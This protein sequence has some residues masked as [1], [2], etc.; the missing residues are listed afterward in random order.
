M[1]GKLSRQTLGNEA[2][3]QNSE[4]RAEQWQRVHSS[5]CQ[6]EIP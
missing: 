3:S 6:I 4:L 5:V 2:I 1:A